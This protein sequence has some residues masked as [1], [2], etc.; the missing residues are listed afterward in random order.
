MT[1]ERVQTAKSSAASTARQAADSKW[2]ERMARLGFV[3]SGLLH[4]LIAYI[5][6]KLAW[7]P[8]P[9]NADQSGAFGLLAQNTAGKVVLWVGAIGLIALAVVELIQGVV[10]NSDGGGSAKDEVLDRGKSFATAVVY[11]VIAFSAIS[12]ARGSGKSSSS[13]N[14]SMSG[15]LMQNTGGRILLVLVALI[16][17]GVGVYYIVKGVKRKFHEDLVEHPGKAVEWLAIIGHVAKGA[18]LVIVA[19]LVAVAGFQ[20]D[21]DKASGLDGALKTLRDAA[22]GPYLL[23]L[24]ALGLAAYGAYSIVRAK[25]ARF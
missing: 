13:Q 12:F 6:V 19:G 4:L 14:T 15:K 25:Y 22:F 18:V 5:A 23:T 8:T 2:L 3:M 1:D 11:V 10:R 21:A 9:E 7:S 24:M 17:A 16:I 20:K